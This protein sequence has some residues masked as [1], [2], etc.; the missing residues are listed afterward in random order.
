MGGF[1]SGKTNLLL[2]LTKQQDDD[3]RITDKICLYVKDPYEAKYQYLIKKRKTNG[4][5]NLKDSKSF[6]KYSH[7][8]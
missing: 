8:M 6:I 7:N 5:K 1:G 4:P 2:N 3:D